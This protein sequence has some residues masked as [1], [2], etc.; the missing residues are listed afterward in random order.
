MLDQKNYLKIILSS[1]SSSGEISGDEGGVVI[2]TLFI[3]A[4]AAKVLEAT[5]IN[6][7]ARIRDMLNAAVI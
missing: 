6:E 5:A 2:E 4:A 1:S 3:G 7:K